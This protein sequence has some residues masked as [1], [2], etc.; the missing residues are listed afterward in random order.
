VNDD[1]SRG[2]IGL[3]RPLRVTEEFAATESAAL[4]VS[5]VATR[6]LFRPYRRCRP[7]GASITNAWLATVTGQF[8]S[9][10]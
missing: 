9:T 3:P 2:T 1:V 8:G 7:R 6:A 10:N 5:L 4:R